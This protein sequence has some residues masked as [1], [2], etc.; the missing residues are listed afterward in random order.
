MWP[1]NSKNLACKHCD[2]IF[3]PTFRGDGRPP[4]LPTTGNVVT[5][6]M[7]IHPPSFRHR[8]FGVCNGLWLACVASPLPHNT[9]TR[10]REEFGFLEESQRAIVKAVESEA[11]YEWRLYGGEREREEAKYTHE[12]PLQSTN[13][14][15]SQ[16]RKSRRVTDI[17]TQHKLTLG[18]SLADAH[19]PPSTSYF[20]SPHSL[21]L[22]GR[23]E[24][25]LAG[26]Y[27]TRRFSLEDGRTLVNRQSNFLQ[28]FG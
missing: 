22:K 8:R 24:G 26:L 12:Q 7:G 4:P 23:E 19:P 2:V 15:T 21:F 9:P 13:I 27:C 3:A 17:S 5:L 1:L 18:I 16:R 28:F 25:M 6:K 20:Y 14:L 10:E 11:N